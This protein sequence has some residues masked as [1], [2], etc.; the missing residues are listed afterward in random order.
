MEH[1]LICLIQHQTKSVQPG[2]TVSRKPGRYAVYAEYAAD[3]EAGGKLQLTIP[4]NNQK[5]KVEIKP[6]GSWRKYV[7]EKIGEIT[8]SKA[9][10]DNVNLEAT[11]INTKGFMN[12]RTIKLQ[13]ID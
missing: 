7:T 12:L 1:L 10:K 4:N 6:T 13:P 8:L 5:M 11:E 3:N 2:G 9:G